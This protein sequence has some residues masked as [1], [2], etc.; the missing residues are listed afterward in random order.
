MALDGNVPVPVILVDPPIQVG[1]EEKFELARIT[2]GL[3]P[4]G[5]AANEGEFLIFNA[6]DFSANRYFVR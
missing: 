3:A 1:Q 4:R 5:A 6:T 2:R